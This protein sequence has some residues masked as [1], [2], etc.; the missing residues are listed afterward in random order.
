M[1][2]VI[3]ETFKGQDNEVL[4]GFSA[5]G[6]CEVVS[7]PHKLTNKFQP[8]DGSVN[9]AAK[10]FI[11]EICNTMAMANE[12]SNQLKHGVSP[13]D[14]KIAFRLRMIK[15]LQAKWIVELYIHMQKIQKTY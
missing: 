10:S 8:L 14:V 9:K 3:T 11:S 1:F 4:K 5:K 6:F 12:V 7:V 2:R 13:C 15:P